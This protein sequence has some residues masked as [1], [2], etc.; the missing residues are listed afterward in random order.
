VPLRLPIV[1]KEKNTSPWNV[2]L[3]KS[4]AGLVQLI[5]VPERVPIQYFCLLLSALSLYLKNILSIFG[6][7]TAAVLDWEPLD[8][9]TTFP[10]LPKLAVPF[11]AIVVTL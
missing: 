10:S 6:R 11:D 8:V 9:S 3:S 1:S 2:F 4:S 7:Y 5:L